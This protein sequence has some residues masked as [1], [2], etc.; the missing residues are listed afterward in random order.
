MW[1]VNSNKPLPSKSSKLLV[2][3]G[4]SDLVREVFKLKCIG[5]YEQDYRKCIESLRNDF[6]SQVGDLEAQLRCLFYNHTCVTNIYIIIFKSYY[7]WII[8]NRGFRHEKETSE[9]TISHLHQDLAAHKT[10]VQTLAFKLERVQFE[11]ESKCELNRQFRL[12][13]SPRLS[14]ELLT[15]LWQINLRSRIWR[16]V[17]RLNR[18]RK[19][20]WT[21]SFRIWK[22]NVRFHVISVLFY[23]SK[24]QYLFG[25]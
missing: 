22:K 3:L 2:T 17:S 20:N 18:R 10:H 24:L 23:F 7:V 13:Y 15:S 12:S 14:W 5:I 1:L 6:A 11:V 4:Q 21:R 16:T 8:Y 25:Y 19:M 9:A